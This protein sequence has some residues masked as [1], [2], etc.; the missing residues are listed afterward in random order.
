MA[1]SQQIHS[2]EET[3]A[4]PAPDWQRPAYVCDQLKLSRSGLHKLAKT[5]K[6]FPQP[7][8]LGHRHTLYDMNAVAAFMESRRATLH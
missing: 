6:G 2:T 5:L 7:V 8:R 4:R 1:N 3:S